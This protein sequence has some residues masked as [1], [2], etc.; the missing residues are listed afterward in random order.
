M[1][2]VTFSLNNVYSAYILTKQNLKSR[3]VCINIFSFNFVLILKEIPA[4]K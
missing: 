3:N 2:I 4:F 1:V